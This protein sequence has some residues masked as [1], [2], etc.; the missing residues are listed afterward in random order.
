MPF[1]LL[2]L[3]QQQNVHFHAAVGGNGGG[4]PECRQLRL[5]VRQIRDPH[6]TG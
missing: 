6:P 1:V 2:L 5:R 4:E 3:L